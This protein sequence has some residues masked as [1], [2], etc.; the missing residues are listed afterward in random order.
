[1]QKENLQKTLNV[2]AQLTRELTPKNKSRSK[3]AMEYSI[4]VGEMSEISNGK[5]DMRLSTFIRIS[6]MFGMQFDEFA[7]LICQRLPEDFAIEEI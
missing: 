6:Q 1:M 4:S 2:I 7:T 5:K 3:L